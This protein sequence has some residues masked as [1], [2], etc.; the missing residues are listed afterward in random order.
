[1]SLLKEAARFTARPLI[2]PQ[3]GIEIGL[4]TGRVA[5]HHPLD[6][7][8]DGGE[9]AP[10]L[11]EGL[12]RNFISGIQNRRQSSPGLAR[13][14][15]QVQSRKIF[16]SRRGKFELRD[17]RKIEWRQ[18]IGHAIRPRHRILNW[19]THIGI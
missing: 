10:L 6:R 16:V 12:D 8:P 3:Y 19:K 18:G 17:L 1:M 2:G 15:S 5:I 4:R 13:S 9:V 7:S 11:E 14:A